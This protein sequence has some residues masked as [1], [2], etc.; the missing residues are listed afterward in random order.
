VCVCMCV[1]EAVTSVPL[2]IRLP[3]RRPLALF[4]SHSSPC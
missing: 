2:K 1:R 3:W 4:E